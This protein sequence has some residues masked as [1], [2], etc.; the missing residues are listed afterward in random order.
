MLLL[1]SLRRWFTFGLLAALLCGGWGY[2]WIHQPVLKNELQAVEVF[3]ETGSSSKA[4]ANAIAKAST[5]NASLLYAWFRLSGK[6]RQIKAGTYAID[7]KTTPSS[8][9]KKLVAGDEILYSIAIPEGWT[10][11]QMRAAVDKAPYLQHATAKLTHAQ[12]MTKLGAVGFPHEGSFFPDTYSYAKNSTD[13][14]LYKQAMQN[15]EKRLQAAWNGRSQGLPLQ[16]SAQMLT[17]ASIV[18]KE[19]G[20]PSDRAEIA[21]VF[22]NRLKLGMRLQTDPTVIYGMGERFAQQRGNIRKSDLLRDTPYNT[23]TRSGLPP[24]PIAL[25]GKAALDAVSKPKPT[26]ALYFVARGDGSSQFSAT[27]AEHNAA[28]NR[29]IRGVK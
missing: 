2:W 29:F 4:T 8:L 27:L 13:L 5:A 26:Q 6:A 1:I 9:L 10:F 19:T 3:I 23:Y 20:L 14:V 17:L 24:T 7:N 28:V 18:E 25:V 21:G 16:N 15:L 22:I 12:L 11:A